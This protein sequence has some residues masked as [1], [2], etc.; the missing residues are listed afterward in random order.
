MNDKELN[1]RLA[2]LLGWE[3]CFIGKTG[4]VRGRPPNSPY[5]HTRAWVADFSS[6]LNAVHAVV[7][8]L[9]RE[10]RDAY[11]KHLNQIVAIHNSQFHGPDGQSIAT[12]DATA[13]QRVQA[14]IKTLEEQ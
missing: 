3:E 4:S 14:L 8:G 6:D 9:T 7:M 1:K 10:Q 11:S 2:E 5:L 12:H 13:L